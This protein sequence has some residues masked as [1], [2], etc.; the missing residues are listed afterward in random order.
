[1]KKLI[2]NIFFNIDLENKI[3]TYFHPRIRNTR[4]KIRKYG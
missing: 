4:V 1:M 3:C 2:E